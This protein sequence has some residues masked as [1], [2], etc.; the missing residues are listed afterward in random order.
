MSNNQDEPS[1]PRWRS[2]ERCS[3]LAPLGMRSRS[4]VRQYLSESL[5]R[6]SSRSRS[7][8]KSPS[9]FSKGA[10]V[11]HDTRAEAGTCIEPLYPMVFVAK[12]R[13]SFCKGIEKN[14]TNH[15]GY[16]IHVENTPDCKCALC[17]TSTWLEKVKVSGLLSTIYPTYT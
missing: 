7:R 3:G 13:R 17:L 1:A 16:V 15:F 14:T 10:F 8:S 9:H 4:P 2:P 11:G 5:F 6:H 12:P